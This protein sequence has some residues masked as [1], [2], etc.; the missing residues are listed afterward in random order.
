MRN[1]HSFLR[2]D[3]YRRCQSL[4][5]YMTAHFPG[6]RLYKVPV[7]KA[8]NNVSFVCNSHCIHR[9]INVL[10]THLATLHTH[11]HQLQK[12]KSWTIMGLVCVPLDFQ[13]M[14]KN[15]IF[16]HATVFLNYLV[17]LLGLPT[18][19]RNLIPNY[20]HPFYQ[21]SKPGFRVTAPL[22]TQGVICIRCGVC[23]KY[24]KMC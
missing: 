7:D 4:H 24:I 12:R 9:L 6:T 17:I 8:P 16:R 19:S 21:R 13:P 2:G 22:A 11:R 1:L 14:I 10:G 3:P 20:Y 23:Q 18:V 15:W 5:E